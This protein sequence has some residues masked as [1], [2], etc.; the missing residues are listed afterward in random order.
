MGTWGRLRP[1]LLSLSPSLTMPPHSLIPSPWENP[2]QRRIFLIDYPVGSW[3]MY[4]P[5]HPGKARWKEA[6]VP[7]WRGCIAWVWPAALPHRGWRNSRTFMWC[8]LGFWQS[9]SNLLKIIL[10]SLSKSIKVNHFFVLTR[11]S[12]ATIARVFSQFWN[13]CVIPGNFFMR[14]DTFYSGRNTCCQPPSLPPQSP[15]DKRL[16]QHF[17]HI[18]F[19]EAPFTNGTH[20]KATKIVLWATCLCSPKFVCWNLTPNGMVLRGRAFGMRSWG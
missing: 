9:V 14:W 5:A 13:Q 20:S 11:K 16:N 6:S 3:R 19:P 12:L 18:I 4:C 17:L 7:A 1:L 8:W 15:P 2:P 10:R